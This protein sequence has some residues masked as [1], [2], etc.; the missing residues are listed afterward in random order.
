ME[1]LK[2][3]TDEESPSYQKYGPSN[4]TDDSSAMVRLLVK[5]GVDKKTAYYIL[6]AVIV[7][8]TFIAFLAI[9]ST[10]SSEKKAPPTYIEDI[11][12]EIQRTIPQGLLEK[13]PSRNA[14]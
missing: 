1:E 3:D 14:R 6:Y 12:L 11:P 5:T 2:F 8:C 10:S 7:L 13:F 9:R 4:E